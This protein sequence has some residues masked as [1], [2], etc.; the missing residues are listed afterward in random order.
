MATVMIPETRRGRAEKRIAEC[1]AERTSWISHWMDLNDY[2]KPRSAKFLTTETNRG[3]KR[4][5]KIINNTAT[6]AARTCSSGMMAGITSPARPWFKLSTGD[7][8]LDEKGSVKQWLHIVGYRMRE[9]FARSNLYNALPMAYSDLGI[10]GTHAMLVLEDDETV[11]RCYPFPVGSYSIATNHRGVVDVCCREFK[12]T[13]RQLVQEFGIENCSA[14]VQQMY[15]EGNFG[16]WIE[17]AHIVQP[18]ADYNPDRMNSKYKRYSSCY[19]ERSSSGNSIR[20][21]EDKFLRESGFD[22]FPIMAPRWEVTGEDPYGNSPSMEALGDI[23]A[24]QLKEKRKAQLI[25]KGANPAMSAPSALRN[26]HSS[27]LAGDVTYYD[28]NAGQTRFEPV[29]TPDHGW[30]GELKADIAAD[31]FRIKRALF[32]DLFLMLSSMDNA[33]PITATEVAERKEEK[34]LVLGPVLERLNDELLDPLIDRTFN[35]MVKRGMIPEAPEELRGM[36]LKVE[37]VSV[38]AQAMKMV[39]IGAIERGVGFVG[40]LAAANPEVLDKVNMDA[41]ID[42]YFERLGTPPNIVRSDDE[43]AKMRQ[44]RMQAA[45]AQKAVEQGQQVAQTLQTAS[46]TNIGGG[47]NALARVIQNMQ[48][49]AT[50]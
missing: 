10:F 11:I 24:L 2:I 5:S 48:G 40:N 13:V 1:R 38:M 8:V 33:Q 15:R 21:D 25:D 28:T 18:N 23:K 6:I 41:A 37:Y 29:Y 39:G 12:M 49:A 16:Q 43:V 20:A 19:L 32:E 47:D 50:V 45:A 36:S 46:Q 4:N 30:L 9:V 35:I 42:N 34:L 44:Q 3:A 27:V 22:E 7:S 14:S 26:Q 31:E 17:V